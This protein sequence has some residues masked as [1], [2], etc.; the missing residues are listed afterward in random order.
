MPDTEDLINTLDTSGEFDALA[1]LRPGEPYFALIGRDRLAPDLV[2]RWAHENRARTMADFD[3]GR[4]KEEEHHRELRKS[5]QAEAVAW[6]MQAYKKGHPTD[7]ALVET[8]ETEHY[9]GFV[10]DP[11]TAE[12][13][14]LL[15]THARASNRIHNGIA[16]LD[17]ARTL[18]TDKPEEVEWLVSIIEL[19]KET[20]N[21]IVP[22]RRG[23][24]TVAA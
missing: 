15:A 14:R 22:P 18:L 3:E 10:I 8:A 9:S 19:L 20:A 2:L 16:A 11:E 17:E 12:R 4:V 21:D 5:T 24:D 13:D 6:A 23:I 1:K 7:S